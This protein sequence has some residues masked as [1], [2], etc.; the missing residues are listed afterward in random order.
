MTATSRLEALRREIDD[1]DDSIHDLLVRRTEVA[2]KIGESKRAGADT[3]P[4]LFRPG[5]EARVLRRLLKRHKGPLPAQTLQG[6]W[7]GI[8]AANLL[9]QGQIRIAVAGGEDV[10]I[11][12]RDHFG[13]LVPTQVET[14]SHAAIDGVRKGTSDIAVLPFP[15]VD[16]SAPWW[17]EIKEND[18]LHAVARIPLLAE[19][20]APAAVLVTVA[21]PEPSGDDM[22]LVAISGS[23]DNAA[24]LVD[25]VGLQGRVVAVD[26]DDRALLEIGGFETNAASCI[27]SSGNVRATYIG[28]F[29]T[30]MIP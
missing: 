28:A 1:L 18:S 21:E 15:P 5:R 11:L 20:E 13:P 2:S 24:T 17:I 6:I 14:D 4:R 9:L 10:R 12:A 27:A 29:A 3:A 16:T 22:T 23:A 30:R 19:D 7:R 25:K 8:I 26:G